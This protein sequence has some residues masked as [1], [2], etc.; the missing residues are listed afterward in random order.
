MVITETIQNIIIQYIH[1]VTDRY[2]KKKYNE[3]TI[4]GDSRYS[5]I[6]YSNI[7]L[8]IHNNADRYYSQSLNLLNRNLV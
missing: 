7:S 8:I 5:S 4:S 6:I 2:F 1:I 3:T